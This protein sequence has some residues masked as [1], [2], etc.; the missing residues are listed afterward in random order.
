MI[1]KPSLS[2]RSKNLP[3]FP[4]PATACTCLCIGQFSIEY[5]FPDLRC[6]N[7]VGLIFIK[8]S[9]SFVGPLLLTIKSTVFILLE[10]SL[11]GPA[12]KV[13]LFPKRLLPSITAISMCLPI[14]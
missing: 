12:G 2:K 10:A 13:K 4:R 1:S 7:F 9:S 14:L 5:D 11:S 3:G 8:Y 6:T